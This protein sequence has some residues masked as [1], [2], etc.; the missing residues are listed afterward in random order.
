MRKIVTLKDSITQEDVYPITPGK[1]VID[2]NG[3]NILGVLDSEIRNFSELTIRDEEILMEQSLNKI[4]ELSGLDITDENVKELA[5][6]VV[7]NEKTKQGIKSIKEKIEDIKDTLDKLGDICKSSE[8]INLS[9]IIKIGK[10]NE[11]P[12]DKELRL[13]EDGNF[14]I[15][16]DGEWFIISEKEKLNY[17]SIISLEDNSTISLPTNTSPNLM[18]KLNG[19][20]WIQWDY[21]TITLDKDDILY[22]KG[23][24]SNEFSTSE[25]KYNNFSIT[26]KVELSGNI[27]SLLYGDDFENNNNTLPGIHTFRRLFYSCAGIISAKDLILPATTLKVQCYISMFR[28]CTSLTT[29]PQL[30][31]TSLASYCYSYMF[32]NCTSITT[33]PQ[34]PATTLASYCYQYMFRDCTSLTTAPQLPATSLASYCYRGMFSGCTSLTETPILPATTLKEYCYNSMFYGCKSL[35]EAP[36]LPATTLANFCYQ[37]MFNGCTN[38]TSAPELPATTS[39]YSC[40]N[41][42]FQNCTS[43]TTVPKLPATTLYSNCYQDMFQNCTSLTEAPQLPATTLGYSCYGYMFNGCTSLTTAPELP[44]TTL[45]GSCYSNMFK[46]CTSLTEAPELPATTLKEHCYYEMFSGCTSLIEAPQLPATTLKNYCYLRMFNGCSKL[47]Y[48]TMLATDI[49]ATNCLKDWVSGV[50]SSGTFVKHPD[51]TTLPSGTSGIPSGWTVEEID[52]PSTYTTDS[53]SIISEEEDINN[54]L[55]LNYFILDIDSVWIDS[56]EVWYKSLQLNIYPGS[57]EI[58]NLVDQI[59]SEYPDDNEDS[60]RDIYFKI[61]PFIPGDVILIYQNGVQV[62]YTVNDSGD[63]ILPELNINDYIEIK[64]IQS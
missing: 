32:Q 23:N 9:N 46:G 8:V 52:V 28:D 55:E 2:K 16:V 58:S 59:K 15:G 10:P 17:F 4:S 19:N 36:Q 18:Y 53:I 37:D 30:P 1:L 12:I 38:L 26:G 31:A 7:E 14:Y 13:D 64:T 48:I 3:S 29:A 51:M 21:N 45:A 41:G 20:D 25:S 39:T 24:N 44:A 62:D 40:Y 5:K 42:M 49:S 35:T 56:I 11:I 43:L 54:T 60:W 61:T 34:L 63:Y 47:N 22:L 50:A 57:I 33:A 27:M 6:L